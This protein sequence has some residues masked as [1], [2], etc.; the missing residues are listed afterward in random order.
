[1]NDKMKEYKQLFVKYIVNGIDK[2]KWDLETTDENTIQHELNACIKQQLINI[3]MLGYHTIRAK[4]H[5]TNDFGQDVTM[6]L[7]FNQYIEEAF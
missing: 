1:M 2:G 5:F 6:I 7:Q 3:D 4:T